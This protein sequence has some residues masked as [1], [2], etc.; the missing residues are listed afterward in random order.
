MMCPIKK[1][2]AIHTHNVL[3][4]CHKRANHSRK[5][6]DVWRRKKRQN[7]GVSLTPD[8]DKC[9]APFCSLN[10][11]LMLGRLCLS[12]IGG[13]PSENHKKK[14]ETMFRELS[15]WAKKRQ[16]CPA[17]WR[18]KRERKLCAWEFLHGCVPKVNRVLCVCVW[19]SLRLN[20]I[21]LF[22]AFE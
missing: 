18:G 20:F 9:E 15:F 14:N 10:Y 8:D 19:V 6:K 1:Q 16:L 3:S 13:F 17:K 5:V 21:L 22:I 4:A 11:N 2:F 7:I 12:C